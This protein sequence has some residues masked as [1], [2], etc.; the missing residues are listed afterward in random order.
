MLIVTCLCKFL[1]FSSPISISKLLVLQYEEPTSIDPLET[2]ACKLR[3][4]SR[5]VVI[6]YGH[7]I[8]YYGWGVN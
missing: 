7:I 3:P 2:H 5:S 4:C 8:E 1:S 6:F